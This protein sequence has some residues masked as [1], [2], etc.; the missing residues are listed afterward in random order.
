[1]RFFAGQ[2]RPVAARAGG[3]DTLARRAEG[4]AGAVRGR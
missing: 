2:V 3:N 4:V 1:M